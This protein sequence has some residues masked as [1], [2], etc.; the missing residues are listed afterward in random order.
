MSQTGLLNILCLFDCPL[1]QRR[2]CEMGL[3][4][5]QSH[6]TTRSIASSIDSW[7]AAHSE[8]SVNLWWSH[9]I[10]RSAEQCMPILLPTCPKTMLWYISGLMTISCHNKIYSMINTYLRSC[11]CEQSLWIYDDFLSQ[12]DLLN[13]LCLCDCPLVQRRF[14][15][16]RLDLWQ[17]HVTTRSTPLRHHQ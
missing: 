7:W 16:M 17:S 11:V 10:N 1:V 15:E 2:F 3:D 13:I 12:T 6:V 9:V 4:S 14:G 5:W 8:Q